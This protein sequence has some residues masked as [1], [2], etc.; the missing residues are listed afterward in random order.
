MVAPDPAQ[1]F[2]GEVTGVI[3]AGAFVAF[4]D[5]YEGML[6]VRKLRGDWWE[7]NEEG[8]I[9]HGER[10]GKAIRIGDAVRVVVDRVDAPRGRVDLFPTEL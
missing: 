4:G 9:L 5:G 7:L 10:S 2:D 1:E 6:P 3:G 8:T